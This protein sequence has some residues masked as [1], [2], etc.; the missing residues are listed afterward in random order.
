[1]AEASPFATVMA[2]AV[3]RA[4]ALSI[5]TAATFAFSS[6]DSRAIRSPMPEPAPVTGIARFASL[7]SCGEATV[8]A[9]MSGETRK[10]KTDRKKVW[11]KPACPG[12]VFRVSA[13]KG[14]GITLSLCTARGGY[15]LR[16]QVFLPYSER[17]PLPARRNHDLQTGCFWQ[18]FASPFFRT[19]LQRFRNGKF[20]AFSEE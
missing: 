5:S 2:S 14:K 10:K 16:F 20:S 11:Q 3:F 1:M 4:E 6:P 12:K 15:F 17:N 9:K 13:G 18:A 7:L 8:S 19:C